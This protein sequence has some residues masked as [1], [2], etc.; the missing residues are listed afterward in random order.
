[1]ANIT[2]YLKKILASRYGRDVR[3]SIH[4]GIKAIND[5]VVDY[6]TTASASAEAAA[7]S[8]EEAATS[9]SNVE[10][11]VTDAKDILDNLDDVVQQIN[12]DVVQAESYANMSCAY[13]SQS[14]VSA[15]EAQ[16]YYDKSK[17]IYDNIQGGTVT[18]EQ[19]STRE[20]IETGETL[21]T[22][23]GKIK[24][25]FADL[26]T[27]AFTGSYNDLADQPHIPSKPYDI[28]ALATDG[29]SANNTVSFTTADSTT[30]TA[31][32]DVAVIISGEKHSSIFNKISTMFKNIRYLY[33]MLGTTDI[34]SIGDG[35]AKGAIYVLNNNI[36]TVNNSLSNTKDVIMKGYETGKK[37]AL[38]GDSL[39]EGYGW[40][41]NSSDKTAYNDGIMPYLR[42]IYPN[43]IWDN[44]GQSTATFL[45]N[46]GYPSITTKV[47]STDLSK[48]DTICILGGIND[49]SYQIA[50]PGTDIMGNI[51]NDV[52]DDGY[53]ASFDSTKIYSAIEKT[54]QYVCTN[55]PEADKI[56]IITGTA[57][58]ND[59]GLFYAYY[60]N[61][62][63]LCNKW[64]FRVFNCDNHI[65]RYYANKTRG[66]YYTDMVHY[67][68]KG[69]NKLS[70]AFADFLIDGSNENAIKNEC[71]AVYSTTSLVDIAVSIQ[72]SS[73][74]YRSGSYIVLPI[75]GGI[76]YKL[77]YGVIGGAGIYDFYDTANN[78]KRTIR[79]N[80][81]GTENNIT[82]ID[83]KG[84]FPAGFEQLSPNSLLDLPLY[85]E[86]V[87][88]NAAMPS[89]VGMPDELKTSGAGWCYCKC[90]TNG[91]NTSYR[92]FILQPFYVTAHTI[93][94][95]IYSAGTW[96]YKAV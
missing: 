75:T 37:V 6:G 89:I 61:I 26:K 60:D 19:A 15:S 96:Y 43:S 88:N 52:F 74:W 42:S 67:N 47:L 36:S 16:N 80:G 68:Y 5:E 53:T 14:E 72:K 3:Q 30:A 81:T 58:S 17:E 93:Y 18:F 34:S 41:I 94:T 13:A 54:L 82:V 44:Y 32:T 8:A 59:Y 27:V 7:K 1:M 12:D 10:T 20:N 23:F 85:G 24:K 71:L 76:S 87:I 79:L 25:Y 39:A 92:T 40:W 63:R 38:F 86:Y 9:E 95:A 65:P 29:D 46:S 28:G 77:D 50:N 4:D 48:Y 11:L 21:A 33:K 64:G 83:N 35:T 78:I 55:R 84:C 31:W 91:F 70:Q 22:I 66:N 56:F 2:E 51:C 73:T 90:L 69:Y 49:L 62:I 57:N 45:T